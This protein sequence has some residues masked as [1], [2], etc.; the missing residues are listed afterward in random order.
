MASSL[1][2]RRQWSTAERCPERFGDRR[3]AC[4][5]LTNDVRRATRR[6]SPTSGGSGAASPRLRRRRPPRPRGHRC[7]RRA[8]AGRSPRSRRSSARPRTARGPSRGSPPGRGR[9]PGRPGTRAASTSSPK[10]PSTPSRMISGSAAD[11]PG[12]DRRAAGERLDRDQPERL[13]PR[14]GHQR[15]VRLGEQ[16]VA[17][18]LLELA[19]ELDRR[20]GRLE[21][22]HED[23]RR[24][25]PARAA[26]RA[27]LGGDPERAPG[28]LRDLDR[29]DDP[30]LRRHPADEAQRVAAAPVERRV[31]EGQAVVD[32]RR[33]TRRSGGSTPGS[34]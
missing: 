21:R 25:S 33:P 14:A 4:R 30:L 11:P 28:R 17:V 22:G 16:L 5:S 29:L 23:V 31:V 27:G 26:S 15:R 34:R 32:D 12:D 6:R 19:E 2:V 20:A 7:P 3:G 9:R 24:S 1:G 18:R 8:S 13:R 10:K